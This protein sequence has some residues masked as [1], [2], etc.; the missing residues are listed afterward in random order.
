MQQR[1]ESLTLES[2]SCSDVLDYAAGFSQLVQL[3]SLELIQVFL[4]DQLLPHLSS[5]PALRSLILHPPCL[6]DDRNALPSLSLLARLLIVDAPRLHC[7]L[8]L[9]PNP[10]A[11]FKRYHA[12]KI[13]QKY[14]DAE[15]LESLREAG[16][17]SV[18][19]STFG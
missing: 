4:I 1:L 18:R 12:R 19:S 2:Y 3:R 16:R 13:R 5:A 17:F 14:E 6:V 15:E 9:Q 10:R 8:V 7:T 11:K